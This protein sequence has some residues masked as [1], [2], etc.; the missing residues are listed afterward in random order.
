VAI[1]ALYATVES[2]I[3]RL[4]EYEYTDY[5]GETT[6]ECFLSETITPSAV[7][8]TKPQIIAGMSTPLTYEERSE[9]FKQ[10]L[11][12]QPIVMVIKS[13][14]RTLSNYRS[15]VITDDG[16][17]ACSS[18]D[19]LDHA[20]LMVGYDDTADIPYFKIKNSWGTAWGEDG[21]I[22]IAQAAKGD[23]GLF[24]MLAEGTIVQAQ[25]V[26]VQV[27]D[28]EQ[29]VPFPLYA[30]LLIVFVTLSLCLC[31]WCLYKAMNS[32]EVAEE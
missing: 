14:C 30:I 8:V 26:T 25:N 15:G 17:C 31:V 5:F 32:K 10:V 24:G 19:C 7:E 28:Q 27:V 22:R 6:E 1:A 2:G 16:D 11:E 13:A 4:N 29:D 9:I 3:S 20:V 18:P 23:Y 12:Q 21:Y